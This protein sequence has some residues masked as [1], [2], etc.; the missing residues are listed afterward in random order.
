M[1]RI[2]VSE[3]MDEQALRDG[4]AQ[5]D[6]LYDPK[7]VDDPVSLVEAVRSADALIVRNRTQVRGSLLAGATRLRVVG[8]LGVGLDNIDVVAC[9]ARGVAVFP[10][11]GANDVSVAEYVIGTAMALLR[12]AYSSTPLLAAGKW[13]REALSNGREIFGK[14]LGLVGFGSIARETA[15]RALALGMSVAAFDPFVSDTDPAWSSA[16]GAIEP[17]PLQELLETSDVISLHTPLT[18]QTRGLID[19]GALARM[20]AGAI[21]INAARGGIVDEA[22]VA[23]ALRAREL[24]GAA[25]DV[26]DDEPLSAEKP[27]VFSDAPNLILT[28]HIA[29]VTAESNVRVSRVTVEAVAR[30][31]AAMTLRSA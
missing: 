21:L 5:H 20:K 23:D 13:P 19:A 1:A 30:H 3:F 16:F 27:L 22:A 11:A 28:P 29:G 7:L 26:F 31:L 12:R 15:K 9:K 2:V 25:L 24:G 4:L 14:R 8:R 10:A 17:L 18:P 6:V